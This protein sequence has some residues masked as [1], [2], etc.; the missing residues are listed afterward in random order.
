LNEDKQQPFTFMK[1]DSV[2]L[3][4]KRK[5]LWYINLRLDRERSE[6]KTKKNERKKDESKFQEGEKN[7]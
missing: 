1:R 6:G 5:T 4:F 3:L 2:T 7:A